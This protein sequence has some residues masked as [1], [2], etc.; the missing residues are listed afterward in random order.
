[1]ESIG[2]KYHSKYK[3]IHEW[4]IVPMPAVKYIRDLSLYTV[5]HWNRQDFLNIVV[6]SVLA[7]AVTRNDGHRG[8]PK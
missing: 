4:L 2:L 1:M 6:V 7:L 3:L 8:S 5:S